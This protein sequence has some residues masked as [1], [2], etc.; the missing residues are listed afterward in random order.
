MKRI[1]TLAALLLTGTLFVTL[2]SFD[3]TS[4]VAWEEVYNQDG[5]VVSYELTDCSPVVQ[6]IFKVENRSGSDKQISFTSSIDEATGGNRIENL[7]FN[8]FLTSGDVYV[9]QC[10]SDVTPGS[11]PM[12]IQLPR[13]YVNPVLE[14]EMR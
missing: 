5:I 10:E 12:N 9:G 11:H 1:S 4:T 13:G 14:I 2:Q 8:M 7:Y 3:S 6:L